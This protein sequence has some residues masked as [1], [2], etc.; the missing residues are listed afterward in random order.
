MD[1]IMKKVLFCSY[2][3]WAAKIVNSIESDNIEG[4]TITKVSTKKD[5]MK[6][7]E[8][9]KFDLIFFL[10]WS[11]IIE[12]N[13]VDNNFCICLHPSLLPMYRGG[14]PLQNQII[15]GE[16]ESG[17]SLFKMDENIDKGPIIYQE[18]FSIEDIDLDEVFNSI[19]KYGKIGINFI[20]DKLIRNQE[21]PLE[22]QNEND[23]SYFKRRTEEMSEIE[24]KDFSEFTSK[25]LHNKIRCLQDPYPNAFI[26]CKDGSILYLKKSDYSL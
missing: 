1:R 10:G 26:K 25:E 16:T 20:L 12:K 6:S 24:M 9:E 11:E 17:I 4:I 22:K 7:I 3:E 13:I 2:R 19:I 14:S 15:N 8:K 21:I 5:L 23:A 18:K